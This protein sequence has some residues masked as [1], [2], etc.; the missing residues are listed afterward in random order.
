MRATYP[1][2][3]ILL[4]LI[5]LII[6]DEKILEPTVLYSNQSPNASVKFLKSTVLT[7]VKQRR[8]RWA[9]CLL[10]VTYLPRL[11]VYLPEIKSN[12]APNFRQVDVYTWQSQS[13]VTAD[14]QSAS[15]SWCRAPSGTHDQILSSIY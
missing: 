6:S 5:C 11:N 8:V 13:H 7:L 14:G 3:L 10:Q 9:G 2:H 1:A 12:S 4:D 15:P